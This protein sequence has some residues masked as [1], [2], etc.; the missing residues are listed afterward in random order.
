MPAFVLTYHSHHVVGR[1]Y[2]FNDHAAL[3][4]DLEVLTDE[5]FR[6][7]PLGE[8]VEMV[9]TG[10][11][12]SER[13][14]AITFDDGPAYDVRDF[15]HPA[16]G[17]QKSF[18]RT[19]EEFKRSRRGTDQPSLCATSFVI[20]SPEAR[21]VMERTAEP[22]YTWLAPGSMS[23]DWWN[24]AIDDGYLAIAN[25]SW[26]HLH[27]ALPVVAHSRQARADFASVLTVEDADAQIASAMTYIAA[28]TGGRAAPYFAYP[29]G[30]YNDYLTQQYFPAKGKTLGIEA[31]FT[32]EPRPVVGGESRWCL[33]RYVCGHHWRSPQELRAVLASAT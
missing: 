28:H 26:D 24:A 10:R 14:A 11:P 30:H 4:I 20:A 31:A 2:A 18:G 1:D 17:L 12:L 9:T 33:P 6:V 15:D 3:P 23:D 22:L 13:I 16:F 29:F 5:R 8:L 7:V 27:P 25:H 21:L 32:A 19:L